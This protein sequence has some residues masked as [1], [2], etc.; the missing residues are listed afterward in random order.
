VEAVVNNPDPPMPVSWYI[1][2]T[3]S[4][5]LTLLI[6]SLCTKI[7]NLPAIAA[8]SGQDKIGRFLQECISKTQNPETLLSDLL[9]GD[10]S[11]FKFLTQ[12]NILTLV[13]V[14]IFTRNVCDIIIIVFI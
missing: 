13:S 5:C 2:N 14:G 9:D 3:I 8:A 11:A 7:E 6:I 1:I 4:Q 10:P 12:N